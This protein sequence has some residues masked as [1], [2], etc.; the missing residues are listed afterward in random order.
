MACYA[1]KLSRR[2]WQEILESTLM[3][4]WFT[5]PEENLAMAVN[6]EVF[7][8]GPGEFTAVREYLLT[9]YPEDLR[10]KRI[11]ARC[12]MLAQTGQYNLER[13]ICREQLVTASTV[14]A[15]FVEEAICL[16]FLLNK[17]YK[18]YY[19]WAF[20]AMLRLPPQVG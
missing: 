4:D 16:V 19:K 11:A 3:R 7:Y 18:P 10:R 15:K 8:D 5:V 2:F 1:M 20:P 6:G 9:G 17:T 14:C 13:C 12:M